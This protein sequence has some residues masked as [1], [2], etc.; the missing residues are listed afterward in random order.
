MPRPRSV[1]A[2]LRSG[3]RLDELHSFKFL[4]DFPTVYT[5]PA[6]R[7]KRVPPSAPG[8]SAAPSLLTL[9]RNWSDLS[10]VRPTAI[11]DAVLCTEPVDFNGWMEPLRVEGNA[12]RVTELL[13]TSVE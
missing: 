3:L 11:G 1:L 7:S 6:M 9:V 10:A 12:E 4:R 8:L 13:R 2:R 5:P